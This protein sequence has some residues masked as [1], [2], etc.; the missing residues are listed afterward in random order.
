MPSPEKFK[1]TLIEFGIEEQT[2]EKINVGYEDLVGSSPKSTKLDYFRRAM[3]LLDSQVPRNAVVSLMDSNACCK[4][5][6]A[7]EKASKEFAKNNADKSIAERIPLIS[8]VKNMG[9]PRL[10]EDGKLYILAVQ[11][12][13]DDRF[14][15]VCPS[16]NTGRKQEVPV[17]KTYCMCCAGHFRYHYQIMLGCKLKLDCVLTSPLD[18]DGKEPCSF[19]FEIENQT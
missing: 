7:R 1:E 13:K 12:F 8:G 2:I 17:S 11:Y 10:T 9:A 16:I 14:R 5:H 15:C 18:S 4:S 6:T 3:M 19:V